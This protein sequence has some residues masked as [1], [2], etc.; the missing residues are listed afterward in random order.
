M[1]GRTTPKKNQQGA[2]RQKRGA[3]SRS[4]NDQVGGTH[5]KR[6]KIQPFDVFKHMESTGNVFVDNARCN[7]IKYSM[8]I[9][10]DLAKLAQDLRKGADYYLAAA[11]HIEQ[12]L[13]R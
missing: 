6:L 1:A 9:K 5:Y 10:G 12:K 4:R 2:S 8:R 3:L 11:Q 13:L 7:G